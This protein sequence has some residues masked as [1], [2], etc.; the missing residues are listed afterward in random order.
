[1]PRENVGAR[2]QNRETWG[3]GMSTREVIKSMLPCRRVFSNRPGMGV[4]ACV[5]DLWDLSLSEPTADQMSRIVRGL[6]T[7]VTEADEK[8][9]R[10]P[11]AG[12]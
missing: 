8:A 11:R 10:R 9:V 2:P 4:L 12:P 3:A 5:R 1:M 6:A 7:W